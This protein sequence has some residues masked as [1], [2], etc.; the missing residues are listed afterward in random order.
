M[1][2]SPSS[3]DHDRRY[4]SLIWLSTSLIDILLSSNPLS[5]YSTVCLVDE[6]IS[7][8]STTYTPR[9]VDLIDEI[10]D[11]RKRFCNCWSDYCVDK[12]LNKQYFTQRSILHWIDPQNYRIHG[13]V[14][15]ITPCPTMLLSLRAIVFWRSE[16]HFPYVWYVVWTISINGLRIWLQFTDVVPCIVRHLL[17]RSSCSISW[18]F[19]YIS[20]FLPVTMIPHCCTCHVK[21]LWWVGD[22]LK[23]C[24]SHRAWKMMGILT[25]RR[26]SIVII[27][28]LLVLSS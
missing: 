26:Q 8:L 4:K 20:A 15:D 13:Y 2:W 27:P 28:M 10:D 21:Y 9:S 17:L 19:W 14:V 18:P 1:T 22:Q 23:P 25:V 11:G 7:L 16:H 3:S 12:I 24:Y 6:H 5:P